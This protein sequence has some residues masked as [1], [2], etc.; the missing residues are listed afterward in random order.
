[1]PRELNVAIQY[2]AVLADYIKKRFA[3]TRILDTFVPHPCLDASLIQR[4]LVR[5]LI[6]EEVADGRRRQV[7]VESRE[8]PSAFQYDIPGDFSARSKRLLRLAV[9]FCFDSS[10]VA[11]GEYK[12]VSAFPLRL[13]AW[14]E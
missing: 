10:G 4:E 8:K 12:L 11:E 7:R 3:G 6:G 2:F 1:M 13:F 5:N 9:Q 14:T